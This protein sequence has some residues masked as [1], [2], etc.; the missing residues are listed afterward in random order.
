MA[1]DGAGC[2]G[3]SRRNHALVG[4][5]ACAALHVVGPAGVRVLVVL[6][7]RLRR[8]GGL[9]GDDEPESSASAVGMNE[10]QV[11]AITVETM[12]V[13]AAGKLPIRE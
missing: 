1:L 7:R 2:A 13:K 11:I 3:G 9:G 8:D 4:D 5:D 10:C 6:F 12:K